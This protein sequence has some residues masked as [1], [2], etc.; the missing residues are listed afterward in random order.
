M[1]IINLMAFLALCVFPAVPTHHNQIET[2]QCEATLS[3]QL[4]IQFI[5]HTAIAV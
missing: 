1:S 5:R 3:I 4:G 2:L